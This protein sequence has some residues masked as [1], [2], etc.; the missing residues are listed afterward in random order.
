MLEVPT[1]GTYRISIEQDGDTWFYVN[2]KPALDPGLHARGLW[3]T[4]ADLVAGR[5]YNLSA[6]WFAVDRRAPPQLGFS[7]VTPEIAAAVKAASQAAEAVV[8]VDETQDEGIDRPTCRCRA[9]ATT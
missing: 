4:T 9:T 2:G 8:F 5:Q 7:D 3:S 1:S 6:M